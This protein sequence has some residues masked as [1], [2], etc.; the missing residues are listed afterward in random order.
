MKGVVFG[1][2]LI[3]VLEP[4]SSI[5]PHCGPTNLRVRCH[6]G[7]QVHVTARASKYHVTYKSHVIMLEPEILVIRNMKF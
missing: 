6:I 2:A 7:L 1:N 3:S 4:R 5:A